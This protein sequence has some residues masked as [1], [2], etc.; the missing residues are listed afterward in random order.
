M[1][2][3]QNEHLFTQPSCSWNRP[4]SHF[5]SELKSGAQASASGMR[6]VHQSSAP[7]RFAS[8]GVSRTKSPPTTIF[9]AGC[10]FRAMAT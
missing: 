3:W 5:F 2:M 6:S 8:S 1:L 9:A 7:A 4:Y 10:I